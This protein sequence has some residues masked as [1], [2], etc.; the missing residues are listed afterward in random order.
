MDTGPLED[1]ILGLVVTPDDLILPVNGR[2]QLQA[3]GLYSDRSTVDLT[4]SVDW[5]VEYYSV[6]EV[7]DSLDSEG[8]LVALSEGIS[9]VYAEYNGVK[10][11]YSDVI[12]TAASIDRISISPNELLLTDGDQVQL[13]A[14]ATFTNGE[15]GLFTQQVRWITDNG[16]VVQFDEIGLLQAVGQGETE[17]TAVYEDITSDPIE[18]EVMPYYEGGKPD[19]RI[20]DATIEDRASTRLIRAMV[21]NQGSQSAIG[22]WLDV[23]NQTGEPSVDDIGND[24]IWMEYLGPGHSSTQEFELPLASA[25]PAPWLMV[26]TTNDIE[27]SHENNNTFQVVGDGSSA[28]AADLVVSY[29]DILE[30]DGQLEV[31]IDVTNQGQQTAEFFFVDLFQ[32]Q[33]SA[34]ELYADGEQYLAIE[35]L[36]AGATEYADFTIQGD[37]SNCNAWVLIDG[38]NHVSESNEANNIAG[39]VTYSQ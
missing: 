31:L 9:R 26:D 28:Q 5:F 24:Y 16:A 35:N 19:L 32:N 33:S 6:L 29:F 10:S 36:G 12:V 2:T 14:T 8:E 22:F 3:T 4:S 15:S 1:E 13:Q 39:P 38:Y 27:E 20:Y 34:P 37:C 18:V 7:G 30:Y 25:V 23:F 17:V 21:V 11:N